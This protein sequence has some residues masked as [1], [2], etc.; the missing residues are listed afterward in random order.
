[1]SDN[2]TAFSK[3]LRGLAGR[4]ETVNH[5]AGEFVRDG[6]HSS[7]ADGFDSLLE[8]AKF[9][10][11]LKLGKQHTHRYVDEVAFRW[12]NR[13]R[14]TVKS[15]NGRSRRVVRLVPVEFQIKELI[16]A[17]LGRRISRTKNYSFRTFPL[18]VA[19][20]A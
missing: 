15:K 14:E 7:T 6:V 17:G 20:V 9:G 19:L 10:V 4:H 3:A 2:Q 18:P 16:A 1:M 8:R 11:W 13:I 12:F 5:S